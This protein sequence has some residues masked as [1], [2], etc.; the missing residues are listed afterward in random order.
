MTLGCAS[1]VVIVAVE[2]S[3]QNVIL[4]VSGSN[5][6]LDHE[7]V[8]TTRSLIEPSDTLLVQLEI[9]VETVLAVKMARKARVPVVLDPASVPHEF[10]VDLFDA[11]LI[12][13]NDPRVP[14][15]F[16]EPVNSIEDAAAD[17][18]SWKILAVDS[19][20]LR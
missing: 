2:S 5:T 4:A 15:I 16:G 3:G 9:S 20:R 17:A 8:L 1:G 10:P 18:R 6:R 13:L 14:V 7:G 12:C 19:L 11:D